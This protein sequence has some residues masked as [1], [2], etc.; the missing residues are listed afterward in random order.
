M[1]EWILIATIAG[2][3]IV[4]E[5]KDEEAC[6]GRL[7]IIKKEVNVYGKCHS[8]SELVDVGTI[9]WSTDSTFE[10]ND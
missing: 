10:G 6:L 2:S 1:M 7:E 4:S 8:K 5:H 3:L 9:T